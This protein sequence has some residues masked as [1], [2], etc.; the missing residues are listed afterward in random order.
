MRL[1]QYSFS[2]ASPFSAGVNYLPALRDEIKDMF[3]TAYEWSGQEAS[4]H[5][6]NICS[7]STFTVQLNRETQITAVPIGSEFVAKFEGTVEY[8]VFTG[9]VTLSSFLVQWSIDHKNH[10]VVTVSAGEDVA[11]TLT[12]DYGRNIP[13]CPSPGGFELEKGWYRATANGVTTRFLYEGGATV[14]VASE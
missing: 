13:E 7:T 14:T 3:T 5:S 10:G 11:V 9:E 1:S 4:I 6:V 2:V 8:I 12:D